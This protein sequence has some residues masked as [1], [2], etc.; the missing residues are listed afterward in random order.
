MNRIIRRRRRKR[1]RR[2]RFE[3]VLFLCKGPSSWVPPTYLW[4]LV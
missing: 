1:R 4:D 2:R 3:R